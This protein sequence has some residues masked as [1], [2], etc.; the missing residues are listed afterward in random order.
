MPDRR[1]D[2]PDKNQGMPRKTPNNVEVEQGVLGCLFLCGHRASALKL[3]GSSILY[4]DPE[5]FDLH[6]HRHIFRAIQDADSDG[7]PLDISAGLLQWMRDH[8]RTLR[9]EA[10]DAAEIA[11]LA[12]STCLPHSLGYYCRVLRT[13]RLRRDSIELA[14]QLEKDA[15]GPVKD[16]L[17]RAT[18]GLAELRDKYVASDLVVVKDGVEEECPSQ[19]GPASD[20]P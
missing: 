14:R 4:L 8:G 3:L 18:D 1:V 12:Q 7:C 17:A 19:E 5:D 15:F 11:R 2:R 13:I 16:W 6:W 9:S 10:D 20:P